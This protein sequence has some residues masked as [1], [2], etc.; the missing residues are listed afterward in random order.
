MGEY[1]EGLRKHDYSSFFRAELATLACHPLIGAVA[2][3]LTGSPYI[4]LWHDQ[5]LYK[6]PVRRACVGWHTDRQYWLS[7]T[8]DEMLTAWIPFH[9]CPPDMGAIAFIDGSHR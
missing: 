9:D 3:R 2:A 6:P 7:C 5:L 1:G 8:S 4:R